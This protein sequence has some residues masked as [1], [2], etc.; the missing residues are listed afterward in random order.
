[1]IGM[2]SETMSPEALRARYYELAEKIKHLTES[3]RLNE[4]GSQTDF[5]NAEEWKKEMRDI[6]AELK[7]KGETIH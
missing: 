6:E 1:M 3:E 4:F 7:E 5:D 2:E